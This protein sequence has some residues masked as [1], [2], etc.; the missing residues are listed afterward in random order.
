MGIKLLHPV[1]ADLLDL[2]PEGPRHRG[3]AVELFL[4]LLGQRDRDRAVALDA[5]RDAGLGLEPKIEFLRILCQLGHV[6]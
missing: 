5:G 1:E 4:A 6:R 2:N 3:A